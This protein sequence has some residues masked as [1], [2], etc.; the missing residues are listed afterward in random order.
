MEDNV[1]V[2]TVSQA[3]LACA[4]QT[5]LADFE[6]MKDPKGPFI[7]FIPQ[8]CMKAGLTDKEKAE[9]PT[10]AGIISA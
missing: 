1:L 6:F 7:L 2:R 10:L 3:S 9:I 4:P 8:F 5:E